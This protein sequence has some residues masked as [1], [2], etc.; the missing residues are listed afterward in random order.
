MNIGAPAWQTGANSAL[1]GAER[2]RGVHLQYRRRARDAEIGNGPFTI[3][4]GRP[5]RR[6]SKAAGRGSRSPGCRLP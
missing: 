2:R 3:A 4:R 1:I 5:S 6:P